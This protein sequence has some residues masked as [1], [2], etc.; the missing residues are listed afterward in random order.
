VGVVPALVNAASYLPGVT[1]GTIATLFGS[2]FSDI[3]GV[4]AASGFPLPTQLSGTSVMVNGVLAPL[5][6]VAEHDG[7]DQ[8]NFQVP[9]LP[10]YAQELAIVVDNNGKEQT[11]YV[12]NW[13]SQLG[14]FSSLANVSG[15]PLT[16][17]PQLSQ[18]S[19]SRS[20]GPKSLD[21]TLSI[22]LEAPLPSYPMVSRPRL[23]L[24]AYRIR[25]RR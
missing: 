12:R 16:R 3:S 1:S 7:Q 4:Q 18:A 15:E 14:I 10:S 19:K 9:H 22:P 20:I 13:P 21:T 25:T 2:G 5:F 6:A 11:F 8:I 24:L 17:L 23:P